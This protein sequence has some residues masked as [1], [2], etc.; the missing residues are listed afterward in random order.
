MLPELIIPVGPG[1]GLLLLGLAAA[2]LAGAWR[3]SEDPRARYAAAVPALLGLGLLIRGTTTSITWPTYGLMML[4]GC[5][6]VL[7]LSFRWGKQRGVEPELILELCLI[8]G[9]CGLIGART[10]HIV[11][12][13][14][15][16]FANQ[17]PALGANVLT[18]LASGDTLRL[19]THAGDAT[20][21]FAGNET[22]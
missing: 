12:Q 11:E 2:W 9:V 8:G 7:A 19:R 3:W 6:G 15:A 13:W 14:D 10:V 20:V 22:P 18:P 4:L 5:V 16:R 21:I 1:A 17:P